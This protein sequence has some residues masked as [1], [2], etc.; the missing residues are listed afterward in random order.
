[1]HYQIQQGLCTWELI[2]YIQFKVPKRFYV[3]QKGNIT[4]G[5]QHDFEIIGLC[6]QF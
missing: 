6:T 5:S 3:P 1:L 2:E 4:S